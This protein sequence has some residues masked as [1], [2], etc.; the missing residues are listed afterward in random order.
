[1][2]RIFPDFSILCVP[3]LLMPPTPQP[4]TTIV[5]FVLITTVYCS[6]YERTP[7]NILFRFSLKKTTLY[8]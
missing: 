4:V 8:K 7:N 5:K 2:N 6:T 3:S 1:M